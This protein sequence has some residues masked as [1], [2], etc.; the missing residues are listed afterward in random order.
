MSVTLITS[1][2]HKVIVDK[3]VIDRSITIRD[4]IEV[5]D[6]YEEIPLPNVT[7]DV[8]TKIIEYCTFHMETHSE[9]ETREFNQKFLDMERD[10]I[11]QVLNGANFL[12]I[13]DLVKVVCI[14]VA[15]MIRGKSPEE[16][17][18]IFGIE[19]DLTPE[20]QNALI[21]EHAWTQLVLF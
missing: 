5:L 18:K 3:K 15:D 2:F 11:F 4:A 10:F 1:D 20:E 7:F 17:R 19:N 16:I 8:L 14:S 21:S 9:H 12:N 13:Q 6:E